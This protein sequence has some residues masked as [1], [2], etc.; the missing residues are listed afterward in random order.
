MR[1]LCIVIMMLFLCMPLSSVQANENSYL[2][3]TEPNTNLLFALNQNTFSQQIILSRYSPQHFVFKATLPIGT[4][5][6]PEKDDDFSFIRID[7]EEKLAS[8]KI[9]SARDAIGRI[10]TTKIIQDGENLIV[11]I[12]HNKDTITYPVTINIFI[13][14]EEN[15]NANFNTGYL[16]VSSNSGFSISQSKFGVKW[17]YSGSLEDEKIKLITLESLKDFI[18]SKQSGIIYIGRNSCPD[19]KDFYPKLEQIISHY[20]QDIFYYN[21]AIDRESRKEE[22][23]NVLNELEV[24]FIPIILVFNKGEIEYKFTDDIYQKFENYLKQIDLEKGLI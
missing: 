21:T 8:F 5:W 13:T 18:A 24:E 15:I 19:C 12:L 17:P 2:N 7:K 11:E 20:N 16:R 9:S 1:R 6:K 4:A 23:L 22:M 10:I 3:N 14:S